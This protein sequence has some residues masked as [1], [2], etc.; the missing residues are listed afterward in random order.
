MKRLSDN[1]LA[2][3]ERILRSPSRSIPRDSIPKHTL[4][5]LLR[6]GLVFVKGNEVMDTTR[7]VMQYG[8]A[9]RRS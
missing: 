8:K 4:Q 7:G 5:A 6:Q 3:L 9:G 1:A 2:A